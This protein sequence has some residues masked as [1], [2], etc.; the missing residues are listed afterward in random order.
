MNPN[1]QSY[2]L[3]ARLEKAGRA[4]ATHLLLLS[5]SHL[6]CFKQGQCISLLRK[7]HKPPNGNS[8][9]FLLANLQCTCSINPDLVSYHK[10]SVF[11]LRS[12]SPPAALN[13][14]P[15]GFWETILHSYPHV[16]CYKVFQRRKKE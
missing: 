7:K 2:S 10:R 5:Y 3:S 8:L 12:I 11:C 16:L 6:F 14:I 1:L 15:S 9:G 4:T 13:P